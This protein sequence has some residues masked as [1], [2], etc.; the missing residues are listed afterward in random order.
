MFVKGRDAKAKRSFGRSVIIEV[1]VPALRLRHVTRFLDRPQC[2]S[3]FDNGK[4]LLYQSSQVFYALA[5]FFMEM[6]QK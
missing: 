1:N 3:Q 5:M 2:C 4:L 6:F